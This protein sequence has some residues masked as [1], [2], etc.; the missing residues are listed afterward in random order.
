MSKRVDCAHDG[1]HTHGT[2]T[3]YSKDKCRCDEC[4]EAKTRKSRH[5]RINKAF[6]RTDTIIDATPALN[7]IDAL[8]KRGMPYVEIAKVSGVKANT[9]Q[10]IRR[11]NTCY[12][13]TAAKLLAT[14]YIPPGTLAFAHKR[15]DIQGTRLRLRALV[16]V[17]HNL[18]YIA[19][20]AGIE[21]HAIY[22]MADDRHEQPRRWVT[23]QERDAVARL[24]EE[25]WNTPP[26][27]STVAKRRATTTVMRLAEKRGWLPPMALDDDRLDDPEYNPNP[28]DVR[29]A[30]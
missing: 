17:G 25:L 29:K 21:E 24:Y 2:A 7:H 27:T 28:E 9:I 20:R 11:S 3:M 6:G 8:H 12:G 5:H 19:R 4:R 10:D 13:R 16:R 23:R 14:Q 15:V 18:K 1:R 30:S 26:D 22:R